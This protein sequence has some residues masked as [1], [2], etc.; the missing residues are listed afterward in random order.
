MGMVQEMPKFWT[1]G[2]DGSYLGV[3]QICSECGKEFFYRRADYGPAHLTI[4]IVVLLMVPKLLYVY[5]VWWPGPWTMLFAFGVGCL[6][7]SLY[8]LSGF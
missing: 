2:Y 1:R 3:G 8:L 7:L 5:T 4:L 6:G